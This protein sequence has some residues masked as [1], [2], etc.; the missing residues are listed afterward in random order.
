MMTK[1]EQLFNFEQ[2][3]HNDP[4]IEKPDKNCNCELCIHTCD[5]GERYYYVE[6]SA[7]IPCYLYSIKKFIKDL[8]IGT[9]EC[10]IS[11]E[12]IEQHIS[13]W[14]TYHYCGHRQIYWDNYWETLM[15]L[16]VVKNPGDIYSWLESFGTSIPKDVLPNPYTIKADGWI[17]DEIYETY[18]NISKTKVIKCIMKDGVK[19]GKEILIKRA[20]L[21]K[22]YKSLINYVLYKP[23]SKNLE[24]QIRRYD[25]S[26]IMLLQLQSYLI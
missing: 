11:P 20:N 23:N 13:E 17:I 6:Q 3:R 9:Y 8:I 16:E 10:K 14:R 22:K 21:K 19:E 12:E 2:T 24:T 26:N 7:C 5:S 15:D 25:A 18:Q 1:K 4:Q